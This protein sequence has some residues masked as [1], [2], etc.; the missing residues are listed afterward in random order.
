MQSMNVVFFHR[1]VKIDFRTSR[2]K[3]EKV[4]PHEFFENFYLTRLTRLTPRAAHL[5]LVCNFH[6]RATKKNQPK[7]LAELNRAFR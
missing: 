6:L 3:I 4:P 5:I 1:F 2:T 7:K